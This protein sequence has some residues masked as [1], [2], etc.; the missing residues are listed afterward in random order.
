MTP[1]TVTV[2]LKNTTNINLTVE[3]LSLQAVSACTWRQVSICQTG[4]GT[5][6]K[7]FKKKETQICQ[8][9]LEKVTLV[10]R[11]LAPSRPDNDESCT[12]KET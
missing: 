9:K 2:L 7:L 6:L 12:D 3:R 4:A 10:V 5:F 11:I 8:R 1:D